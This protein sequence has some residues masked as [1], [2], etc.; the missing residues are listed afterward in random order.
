VRADPARVRQLLEA[1]VRVD[2]V[3]PDADPDGDG[4]GAL[5]ALVARIARSIRLETELDEVLPGR[6]NVIPTLDADEAAT[7]LVIE[8]HLDTVPVG[9]STLEPRVEGDRLYARGACDIKGGLAAALHALELLA[10]EPE[11]R[12]RVVLLA[13]VD[14]EVGFRG[15]THHVKTRPVSADAAVVL[16]PTGLRIVVAHRGCLRFVI[17][18]RGLAAHTSVPE[19]GRNA[20]TDLFA[21]VEALRA[22]NV[23]PGRKLTVSTIA[24]GTAVNVVPD[25]CRAAI[26]VR[27]RPSDDPA[28]VLT[29]IEAVL[30]GLPDG[31]DC[32][33]TERLLLDQGLDTAP[34][35]AVVRAAAAALQAQRLDA[36]TEL[37]PYG[38]DA[39]KLA[40]A[41]IP[42]IVLGPGDIAQ[43]HT[44]DEWVSLAEVATAAEVYAR[45]ALELPGALR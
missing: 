17:E 5:A 6:P 3:N 26:D 22:W 29:E 43:A 20:V 23:D 35:A 11:R 39:S 36:Q 4:E 21:A 42:S 7:E 18:T 14:E 31:L 24:G 12:T 40:R 27:T 9:G 34:D 41:G 10:V 1:L 13:T 32:R 45:L 28:D 19:R 38:T 8:V 16:E 2:S 30:A 44:D 15:V 37:A 25:R 33:V